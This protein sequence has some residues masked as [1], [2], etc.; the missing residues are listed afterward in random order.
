MI[1]QQTS[2]EIWCKKLVKFRVKST[3]TLFSVTFT[4]MSVQ[5]S[6]SLTQLHELRR[7]WDAYSVN[8]LEQK[9]YRNTEK[10]QNVMLNTYIW[11]NVTENR[12]C[13]HFTRTLCETIAILWNT[14]ILSRTEDYAQKS[15][16][17]SISI[18]VNQQQNTN[19]SNKI[20]FFPVQ[21]RWYMYI[22]A[23][24]ERCSLQK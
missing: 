2:I 13:P 16:N 14:V 24:R 12:I 5:R 19:Y 4:E 23:E 9:R 20:W 10:G 17:V 1:R 8:A 6:T 3:L 18:G 15:L 7:F 11:M 21:I 22:L